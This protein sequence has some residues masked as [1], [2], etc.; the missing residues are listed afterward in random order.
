M[1]PLLS[2][3]PLASL[4]HGRLRLLPRRGLLLVAVVVLWELVCRGLGV[5]E[6]IFPAP[7]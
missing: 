4:L 3:L 6:F 2:L 7:I 1:L 5:S